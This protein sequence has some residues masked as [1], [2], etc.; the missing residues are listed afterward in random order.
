MTHG[1]APAGWIEFS[2]NLNPLGTPAPVTAAIAEAR[3]DRYADLDPAEA[4]A[5]LA[6]DAGVRAEC[7]LLS[8]GA[9]EAIRLIAAAFLD[10]GR[11]VVVGPTYSE[12]GRAARAAGQVDEVRADGPAFDPPVEAALAR[13]AGGDV[14]FVCD[15]NN[16]TGRQLEPDRLRRL[17]AGAPPDRLVVLDQSFLPFAP[18]ALEA[19]E[20][21]ER[22]NV[23]LLRSLTK[24]LAVP[25]LRLGYAVG[26]AQIIARLRVAQDPWSVGAHAIAAAR[27]ASWSLPENARD[28]IVAWR[29]RFAAALGARGLRSI[30]S[31]A[32]FV[33]VHAG[34]DVPALV[35]ALAA[36][37]IAVRSCASFGLPE[38][39]RLAVRPPA[40]QDALLAALSGA[41]A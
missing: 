4:E 40:E 14:L 10:R 22:G 29:D 11:A 5:H 8:A 12:Y 3:Y 9:T 16:P 24:I 26:A 31:A 23:V 34:P 1:G 19:A 17:L 35:A 41:T 18:A 6:H 7:V 36:E 2:A 32:N 20:A 37:R 27:V 38:H 13:T 25:G 33:C 15:P 28:T 39:V 21:I 30:P